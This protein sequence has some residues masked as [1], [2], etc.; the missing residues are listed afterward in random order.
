[1]TAAT[2]NPCATCDCGAWC[3]AR[4]CIIHTDREHT[5]QACGP[6]RLCCALCP[7]QWH[8]DHPEGVD[9]AR[10]IPVL[11]PLRQA[12]PRVEPPPSPTELACRAGI[13][14]GAE[15]FAAHLVEIGEVSAA[16]AVKEWLRGRRGKPIPEM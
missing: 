7:E 5:S 15:E 1:M 10:T 9:C 6:D 12:P 16:E 3:F 4:C 14:R 13:R 2:W 11:P 8:P